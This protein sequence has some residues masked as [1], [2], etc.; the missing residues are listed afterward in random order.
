[1]RNSN[2]TESVP[3]FKRG[4][5]VYITSLQCVGTVV[6]HIYPNE[7]SASIKLLNHKNKVVEMSIP[8]AFLVEQPE[9]PFGDDSIF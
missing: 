7:Y 6:N 2:S 1:M 3:L 5:R 4:A 9:L 8:V